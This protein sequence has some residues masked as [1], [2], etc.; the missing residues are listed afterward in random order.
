MWNSECA[1]HI[2]LAIYSIIS[3]AGCSS[4]SKSFDD[5][6]ISIHSNFSS[7]SLQAD[8]FAETPRYF[9]SGLE[10][11]ICWNRP[12]YYG[13]HLF[14]ESKS[15]IWIQVIPSRRTVAENLWLVHV[16]SYILI[17][18]VAFLM[19]LM[20]SYSFDCRVRF[21]TFSDDFVSYCSR[22]CFA[23]QGSILTIYLPT[24]CLVVAWRTR[25]RFLASC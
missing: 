2:V 14:F 23:F 19:R 24:I 18:I 7:S 9:F 12:W 25:S 8:C 11:N 21:C 1:S 22:N 4:G 3:E 5:C 16:R 20:L 15:M 10:T 17:W 13:W 6:S